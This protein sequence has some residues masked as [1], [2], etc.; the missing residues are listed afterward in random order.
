MYSSHQTNAIE[1]CTASVS[2]M[3]PHLGTSIIT[4]W[5]NKMMILES[6]FIIRNQKWSWKT[7][8]CTVQW[9]LRKITSSQKNFVSIQN[10][11]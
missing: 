8:L 6:L 9:Y 7:I 5:N 4:V 11:C 2:K 3:H 1:F 10:I